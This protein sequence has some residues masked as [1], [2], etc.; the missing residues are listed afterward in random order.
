MEEIIHT[1]SG[2]KHLAKWPLEKHEV[3]FRGNRLHY[4]EV[5]GT[6]SGL[7]PVVELGG[8]ESLD[9]LLL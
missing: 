5:N 9:F 8:I 3:G 4:W 7:Y 2:G 6:G 1:E